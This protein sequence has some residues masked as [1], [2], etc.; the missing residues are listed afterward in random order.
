MVRLTL[1]STMPNGAHGRAWI[2]GHD[3]TIGDVIPGVSAQN[4]PVLKT[5]AGS[6][7]T[8]SWSGRDYF[9]DLYSAAA[10]ELPLTT[11]VEQ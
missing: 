2:N 3:L 7:V 5:V 8:I 10:I 9:L 6:T 4:Q 1:Q 11:E